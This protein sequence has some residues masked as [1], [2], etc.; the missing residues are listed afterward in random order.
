[1]VLSIEIFND[2]ALDL[3]RNLEKL[4]LIKLGDTAASIKGGKA[5]A[6][7]RL[8]DAELLAKI[9]EGEKSGISYQFQGNE[10]NTLG[11]MLLKGQQVDWEKYKVVEQ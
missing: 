1:M 2:T 8:T 10:F 5:K 11:D 9:N 4:Q 3:L 6:R 7:K